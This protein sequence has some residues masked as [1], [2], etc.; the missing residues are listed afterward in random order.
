MKRILV[1]LVV[2]LFG[3]N[4]YAGG[5]SEHDKIAYLLNVIAESKT[6]FIRNGIEY[7]GAQAKTHLQEK[8][9]Y[10]GSYIQ[11]ADDFIAY[12]ASKSSITG[13]PYY[14]K[15]PDGTVMES[16]KWLHKKLSEA[17]FN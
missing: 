5:L 8:L 17:G 3:A 16:D 14:V 6:T 12:I 2:I 9:D 11:S 15:S 4:A 7:S 13:K 1:L 10:A